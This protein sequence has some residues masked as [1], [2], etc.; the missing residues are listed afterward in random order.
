MSE[1]FRF[2]VKNVEKPFLQKPTEK[3]FKNSYKRNSN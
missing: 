3:A 1:K 2:L